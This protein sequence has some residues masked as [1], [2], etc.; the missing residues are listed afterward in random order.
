MSWFSISALVTRSALHRPATRLYPVEKRQPYAKT[1]GHIAFKITDC[2][3]CTLC[4]V[5]CPTG[6]I[7][8]G[9]TDNTWA[10]DH[11][12]CILCGNCVEGCRE[13]CITLSPQPWH[14]MLVQEVIRYR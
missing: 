10:I 1:R 2:T 8:V 12:R 3:F 5:K 4:A 7:V 14:S 13:S 11:G 6:A 9:K